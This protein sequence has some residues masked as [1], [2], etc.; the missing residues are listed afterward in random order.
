V[1]LRQGGLHIDLGR[2]RERQDQLTTTPE[3]VSTDHCPGF[4]DQRAKGP[5][6]VGRWRIAPQRL[7]QAVPGDGQQPRNCEVSE[8]QATLTP[9]EQVVNPPARQLYGEWPTELHPGQFI[10]HLSIAYSAH[11]V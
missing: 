8:E 7:D 1:Q 2:L 9:R 3:D 10:H 4:G 6:S 5:T 11:L